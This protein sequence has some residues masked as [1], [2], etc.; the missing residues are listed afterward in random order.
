MKRL[1]IVWKGAA[2][3]MASGLLVLSAA[4]SNQHA[5]LIRFETATAVPADRSTV[6]GSAAKLTRSQDGIWLSINT[7]QLPPGAY[8]LWWVL[9]N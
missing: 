4:T 7:T 5:K 6:N 3:L 9:F 1:G 8:T 2:I